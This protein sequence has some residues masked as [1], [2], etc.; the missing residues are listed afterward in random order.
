MSYPPSEALE[1]T[2]ER[3]KAMEE[4]TEKHPNARLERR[5]SIP[6]MDDEPRKV[7]V[8]HDLDPEDCDQWDMVL[9]DESSERN[10]KPRY[11]LRIGFY[12]KLDS[13]LGIY[14]SLWKT[15]WPHMLTSS[16][17]EEEREVLLTLFKKAA[18]RVA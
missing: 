1:E 3:V 10:P 15:V 18:L 17:S 12:K 13:G 4:L 5:G 2:I 14:C 6:F 7:W 9:I 11:E 8:D 16:L